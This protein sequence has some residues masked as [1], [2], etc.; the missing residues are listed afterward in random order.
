MAT[1]LKECAICQDR[2]REP[3]VLPCIHSFCLECLENYCRSKNNLPGDDVSCPECRHEFH[4]PKNGVAGLTSRTHDKEPA[5]SSSSAYRDIPL[6]QRT[7]VVAQE[8]ARSIDDDIKRVTSHVEHFIGT[9]T[10]TAR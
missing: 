6:P 4:I 9:T 10:Q 7:A 8:F 5:P 1:S 2:L 3:R